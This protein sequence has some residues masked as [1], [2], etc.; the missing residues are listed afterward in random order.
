MQGP[1]LRFLGAQEINKQLR[2]LKK[3][4]IKKKRKSVTCKFNIAGAKLYIY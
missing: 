4:K 3:V 1:S 2:N